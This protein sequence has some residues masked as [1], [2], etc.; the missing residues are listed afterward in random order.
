MQDTIA[1]PGEFYMGRIFDPQQGKQTERPLIY[2]TDDL[3]THAVVMGMTGSGKTGLCVSMLEEAAL[4]GLPALM[5]D[6]K[7][8]LTNLLLHFPELR[9]AD[10]QPWINLDL[11]RRSNQTIEDLARQEAE[12]WQ[13]GLADWGIG[14]ERLEALAKSVQFA[15]FTPG[16]TSGLPVSILASL[17]APAV[18]WE[19]NREMLREKISGTVTALLSLV[20][21]REIDPVRSREH[22]LLSNL[23]EKAWSSGKDLD[24]GELIL[25]TQ[26]P[27]FQKLGVF[28][29]NTFYPQK[30]RF[31]LAMQL[32]NILASPSFQSWIEGQPLDVAALLYT[33]E[34][35]PRHSVFYIAH[36]NDDERMFFVTLL[37][38]AIESWM[39]TQSGTPSLRSLVYFDEI[40]GYLPP[41]ANPPSKPII[42]RL[43][44]QARAFG[45][46][47][48]LATQNPADVD[49]KGISNTGSWFIGKL[50]T[51]Q[52]KQRLLDGLEGAMA[53]NFDRG[54]YDR[55]ISGLAKRVFLM[56]NVHEKGPILFQTR[57]AM[58]YLAGPLTRSQ[59]PA[60]NT[61][62]GAGAAVSTGI[63]SQTGS[64]EFA[65]SLPTVSAVATATAVATTTAASPLKESVKP[66][67][68]KS[69]PASG[70]PSFSSTRPLL[71]AGLNEYFVPVNLTFLKALRMSTSGRMS[72][73]AVAGKP[74]PE[75]AQNLGLIYQP[76]LFA[77]VGVRYLNRKYNLDSEV[78]QAVLVKTPDRRGLV[79]WEEFKSNPLALDALD[80]EADPDGRFVSL[81]APLSDAKIMASIK[82]DFLDWIFHNSQVTVRVNE[83]LEIYAGPDV[84]PADF[85]KE[86][87]DAARRLY[88]AEAKETNAA[89]KKRLT[90]L[91]Q[92]MNREQR[93]LDGDQSEL[94]QRKMEEWGTHAENLLSMFGGRRRK[95]T[96]SLNKRRMTAQAKE[97]VQESLQAIEA[98]EKQISAMQIEL[99]QTLKEAEDRYAQM[100]NDVNE[101]TVTPLKKDVILDGFGVIWQPFYLAQV[102]GQEVMLPA[103]ENNR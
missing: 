84:S 68:T 33:P 94:D 3:T 42:M 28:D 51:D 5:I 60:L 25:Q 45:V 55:I 69:S 66:R 50:Q 96:T 77:Q 101:M 11:A 99:E 39:R 14:P 22:I 41:V 2:E 48:V 79:R 7:G 100:V 103:N 71:P 54:Q 12:K 31:D 43:L 17:K 23:F 4:N 86:C 98:F 46:G 32:N 44:K 56:H 38:S 90:S 6:P 80:S 36:L 88:T 1:K 76:A 102:D 58:N 64:D 72:T 24:L 78:K 67:E 30:D 92:Q 91:E 82:K 74:F 8:D 89:F 15:V 40:F 16:S 19:E 59:I 35:K 10:F 53:G 85:R 13:K 27:P 63:G 87:S 70:L 81:E 52:D 93:E 97:D 65:A 83:K 37:F 21:L 49:Y 73:T 9:P 61:L 29:I 20:G 47:L 34:G 75:Q 26:N 95:L 62:A 18:P 57:W